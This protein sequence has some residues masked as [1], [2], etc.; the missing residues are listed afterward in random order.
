M[1]YCRS[2]AKLDTEICYN[3]ILAFPSQWLSLVGFW[4]LVRLMF[5]TYEPLERDYG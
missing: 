1:I 5:H 4:S 3:K 2:H